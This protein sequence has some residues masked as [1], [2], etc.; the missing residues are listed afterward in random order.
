MDGGFF[1]VCVHIIMC[2][3]VLDKQRDND[4]NDDDDDDD[5][6]CG[7][8]SSDFLSFLLSFT[9]ARLARSLIHFSLSSNK[10]C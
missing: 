3:Y 5:N 8:C 7:S 1:C 10:T 6:D 9:L 4:Y 2:I